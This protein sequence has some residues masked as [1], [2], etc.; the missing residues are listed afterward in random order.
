M[1]GEN[2]LLKSP[3]CQE[4]SHVKGRQE[5]RKKEAMPRNDRILSL[6]VGS[7]ND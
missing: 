1:L 6:V 7:V 3:G 4:P 2:S 5:E